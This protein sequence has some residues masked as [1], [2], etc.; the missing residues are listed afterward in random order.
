MPVWTMCVLEIE[1]ADVY[2]TCSWFIKWYFEYAHLFS[3]SFCCGYI[4][5]SLSGH[6]IRPPI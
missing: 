2:Y 6:V 1:A 4:V 5:N 3:L